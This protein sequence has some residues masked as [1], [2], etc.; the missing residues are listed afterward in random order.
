[1]TTPMKAIRAKCMDCMCDSRH[2]MWVVIKNYS[3]GALL[4]FSVV[5]GVPHT[6]RH[7]SK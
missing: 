7:L 4:F 6:C 5:G 1:M 2:E 3:Q